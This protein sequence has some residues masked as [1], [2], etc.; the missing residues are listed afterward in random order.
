VKCG[1]V[2]GEAKMGLGLEIKNGTRCTIYV[3][4]YGENNSAL[5]V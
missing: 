1:N 3:Y 4:R 5:G 2:L